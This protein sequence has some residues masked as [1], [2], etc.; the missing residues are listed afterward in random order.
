[1]DKWAELRTAYHV[2]KLGTVSAPWLKNG[3]T[4]SRS[5]ARDIGNRIA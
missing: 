1:M 4:K 5:K 3:S 2:A